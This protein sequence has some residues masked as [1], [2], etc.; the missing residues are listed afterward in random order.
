MRIRAFLALSGLLLVAAGVN[1]QLGFGGSGLSFVPRFTRLLKQDL[2]SVAS[3]L[4]PTQLPELCSKNDPNCCQAD[5]YASPYGLTYLNHTQQTFGGR[6]YTTFF[7]KFH[8]DSLCNSDLD[9][10][11]CCT[12]SADNIWV[13]V[14]P[15]LK[16]KYV[17]FNGK[18]LANTDQDDF[19][20]K[21][22]SVNLK[23]AQAKD[24]IP[25][26]VT[27][28]G[29]ADTL[30]PPPGLAPLPGLCE[31]VV[32]GST[33]ANPNA[34]CPSTI[35]RGTAQQNFVIPP[36]SFQCSASI[37][38][39]PYKLVLDG[40]SAP[41]TVAGQQ[42][43]TYTFR[44]VTTGSCRPD[45]IANCCNAQLSYLEL[46]VT[47][48]PITA[49]QL[50]GKAVAFSTSAFNEPNT[51]SYRSLIV[52][53]LN[54]VADD[55][56]AAGLPLSVTVRLP[57]GNAAV[58]D[59]CDAS[60]DPAQGSC[61][62]YLHSEDG[63]CCPSGRA[64][65]GSVVPSPPDGT[66]APTVNVPAAETTMSFSYY[67]KT[68][69]ASSTTFTFLLANHRP[70]T[71]CT[72]PYCVDVCSWTLYLNPDVSNT[73]AVGHES[74]A[75]SGRQIIAA[76]SGSQP[77][78]LTFTYGPGGESTINFF[79]TLPAGGKTLS[80]LCARNALPG[81]GSK[82]CAAMVR[83][84]GV[85]IMVFFD[86]SDVIINGRSP[87]GA[88]PICPDA[89]PM[90]DACLS[91]GRGRF[92]T[93]LTS[94]VFEF[95]VTPA[96]A[97]AACTPPSPAGRSAAVHLVLSSATVDQLSTYGTV[98]PSGP[99]LALDRND[100]ARWTV[101]STADAKLSFQV[102]GS[103]GLSDVCRQGVTPEQ[104]AGTCVAEVLGDNGCF[105]G[106]VGATS[107]GL[108]VWVGEP[109]SSRG[110]KAGVVVPA[111]VVPAVVLLAALLVLAAWYRR[112][113]QQRADAY[114]AASGGSGGSLQRPLAGA[115]DLSVPSASPSDVHIRVPGASQG[116]ARS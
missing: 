44:M 40:V 19:G 35:T 49:V 9:D 86:E 30:C 17:A 39:S 71:G 1:A 42:Y 52:D 91:V 115:D 88:A 69:A 31:I 45:G 46:K 77:A 53:D 11:K 12:A 21:L 2:S 73:V 87:P 47:D 55:L 50:D 37:A 7:Y 96:A 108:L 100:G 94:A 27:V 72:K 67:E 4:L 28:E 16:V 58:S 18:R 38:N 26:A 74:T 62:Y 106:Y 15:T 70:S 3:Y 80:D 116:G 105:R 61:S 109:S 24:G 68:P 107:D 48:L 101:S 29:A 54:L 95:P 113:R 90:A 57:S 25:L 103:L 32:Q 97:G 102:Q 112:R 98:R 8:S 93:M 20:L 51:A 99:V 64:M 92:N 66:C 43:K 56:G 34:C 83:S 81:Q 23:V 89:R 22:G 41:Q 6:T 59:L 82:A 85:Y 110:V 13:D 33:P 63:F 114:E 36:G 79:V 10:A 84:E 5:S 14:D 75:N 78:Q 60:S 65:S 111:V 76:A 104:P